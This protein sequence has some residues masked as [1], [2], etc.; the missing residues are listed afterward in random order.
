M[1]YNPPI[2]S[3][4]H[5]YTTYMLPFGR[6]YATYHLL[7][8]P[9]TAIDLRQQSWI[10]YLHFFEDVLVV[11]F[12]N[13]FGIF[14][15]KFVEDE[16]IL[17]S[18][19]AYFFQKRVGEKPAPDVTEHAPNKIEKNGPFSM[20]LERVTFGRDFS[21][22]NPSTARGPASYSLLHLLRQFADLGGEDQGVLPFVQGK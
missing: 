8:E 15:R 22:K 14:T 7:G 4:Y 11:A 5:L 6:L 1:A 21:C 9:E 20:H 13:I 18:A 16:P 19:S 12:S 2:G 10:L 3:I 17:T